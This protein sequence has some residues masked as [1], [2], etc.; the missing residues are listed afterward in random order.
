MKQN[1]ATADGEH[2]TLPRPKRK[3]DSTR[4]QQQAAETR[5]RILDAA[6]ACFAEVGYARTTMGRIAERAG[7]SVESVHLA[8]PKRALLIAAFSRAF[9]GEET[10]QA[11]E[12]GVYAGVLALE[13]RDEFVDR[14]SHVVLEGQRAGIG[15]WRALSAAAIEEPEV[16]AL[17]ADLAG[18]RRRDT[19]LGCRALAD[20]GWLRDDLPLEEV[21]DTLALVV[22]FDPY[23]LYVLD[24]GW[25]EERLRAW[26]ARLLEAEVLAPR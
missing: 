11:L 3:Y 15:I 5:E 8:G 13:D 10:E 20:K 21:A 25:P 2:K 12:D 19:V 22:G 4:R 14:F 1:V 16:A 6:A 26:T 7:V 17:Y 9:V 23:Q 24:F 18:R